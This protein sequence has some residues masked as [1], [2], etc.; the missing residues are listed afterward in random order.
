MLI[1]YWKGLNHEFPPTGLNVSDHGSDSTD[2]DMGSVLLD[3]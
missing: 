2:P 1:G 3:R